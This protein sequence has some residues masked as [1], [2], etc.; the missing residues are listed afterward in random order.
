MIYWRL[1]DIVLKLDNIDNVDSGAQYLDLEKLNTQARLSQ[2][3]DS[4]KL[5]WEGSE[6][7]KKQT[8]KQNLVSVLEAI[9]RDITQL[10]NDFKF[11]KLAE[12]VEERY[13]AGKVD[14]NDLYA[15]D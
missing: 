14:F 5:L 10:T 13:G 11:K 2:K 7:E 15:I 8:Q 3:Y 4:L 12:S 9:E 1:L 6:T